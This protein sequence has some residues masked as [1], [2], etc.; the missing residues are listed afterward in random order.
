MSKDKFKKIIKKGFGNLFSKEEVETMIHCL[1]Y[2]EYPSLSC[3]ILEKGIP[4][5][6]FIKIVNKYAN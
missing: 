1:K 5:Q 2:Q 3:L 4:I 6:L